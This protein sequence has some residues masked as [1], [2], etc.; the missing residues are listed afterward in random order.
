MPLAALCLA[1]LSPLDP[2]KTVLVRKFT[3][4]EKLAYSVRSQLT[5]EQRQKGLLT[6]LP[7]DTAINYNFS[8][9][10]KGLKADGVAVIDYNRPTMTIIEDDDDGRRT[11][12]E[13]TDWNLRLSLTPVNEMIDVKD[14]KPKKPKK[15]KSED[16]GDVEMVGP[17]DGNRYALAVFGQFASEA[18]RMALF[19]GSLDSSMDLA[20]KLPLE[21]V[22]VGDTW[23]RT[24]GYQPQKLKGKEG[25][26]AVQR[27]DYTFTYLGP[28][29]VN[30]KQ[31]L[32]IQAK[33]NLKTDLIDY[34]KSIFEETGSTTFL[35]SLPLTL[36]AT[37]DYDLDP[38]TRHTLTARAVSSGG[39]GLYMKG[40]ADAIIEGRYKGRTDVDLAGRKLNAVKK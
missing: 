39:Y 30:G 22:A 36:D 20:P 17:E 26:S 34:V 25:K 27:L 12:I 6:W 28:K 11:K 40:E 2:A 23:Q 7:S 14:L 10:V 24:V 1:L 29:T 37:I 33:L 19:I 4:N 35:N 38:K 8:F 15:E 31:V 9:L 13:K 16:D 32:R 5:T 3:A 18:E 21:A